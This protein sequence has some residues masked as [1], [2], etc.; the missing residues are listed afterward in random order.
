MLGSSKYATHSCFNPSS[1]ADFTAYVD[2]QTVVGAV[3]RRL[4]NLQV[5]II[6][7]QRFPLGPESDFDDFDVA[8]KPTSPM[9][10]LHIEFVRQG[11]SLSKLASLVGGS[12]PLLRFFAIDVLNYSVRYFTFERVPLQERL[13]T[14]HTREVP[15]SRGME[16]IAAEGMSWWR[17]G[18]AP[19]RG[20]T[21]PIAE[22]LIV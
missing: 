11:I 3:L 5:C 12:A 20:A 19:D 9:E 10:M 4:P 17:R 1:P 6:R 8:F 18:E 15:M 7:L 21:V 2:Y 14:L 16:I 13:A 22:P